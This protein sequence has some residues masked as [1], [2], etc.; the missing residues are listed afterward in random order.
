MVLAKKQNPY[1]VTFMEAFNFITNG[2][3]ESPRFFRAEYEI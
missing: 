1:H 3:A 2:Q